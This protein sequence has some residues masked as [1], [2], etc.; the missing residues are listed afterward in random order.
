MST[1]LISVITAIGTALLATV[2]FVL[3]LIVICKCHPQKSVPSKGAKLTKTNT[4]A[5]REAVKPYNMADG[6]VRGAAVLPTRHDHP[7]LT[8]ERVVRRA[9]ATGGTV[10]D[11]VE[12]EDMGDDCAAYTYIDVGKDAQARSAQQ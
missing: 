10:E 2:V 4:T 5:R 3:I 9:G 8:P 6:G 12:Y 7:K 11:E 1:V